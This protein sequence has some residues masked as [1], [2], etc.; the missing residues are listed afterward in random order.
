MSNLVSTKQEIMKISAEFFALPIVK[1]ILRGCLKALMII[2]IASM[3][4]T[5]VLMFETYG[6]D[7]DKQIRPFGTALEFFK[8]VSA[9]IF[10]WSIPIA[11]LTII[12]FA[13]FLRYDWIKKRISYKK[14]FIVGVIIGC[15]TAGIEISLLFS[16]IV[17]VFR[18]IVFPS[19]AGGILGLW[20]TRDVISV[21]SDWG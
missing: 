16:G 15:L 3:L 11:L 14:S 19:I 13:F 8:M 5:C 4:L 12:F 7:F 17:P 21:Y 2:P 20:M 9:F 1:I 6:S 18:V 10:L